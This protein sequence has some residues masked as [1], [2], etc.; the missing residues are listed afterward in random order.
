MPSSSEYAQG[1]QNIKNVLPEDQLFRI[2]NEDG[3]R[4]ILHITLAE[5]KTI[6]F[7][8]KINYTTDYSRQK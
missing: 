4:H 1:H 5:G 3:Q 6:Y 2:V 8:G 7:K